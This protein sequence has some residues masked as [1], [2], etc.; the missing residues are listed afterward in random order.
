MNF[1]LTEKFIANL[2]QLIE[3]KKDSHIK[4]ILKDFFPQ[5]IAEIISIIDISE[6]KYLFELLKDKSPE[7]IIEL[8]EDL[9]EILLSN[10]TTKK[11]AKN[12]IE[13][14]E[15]DDAA[16]VIQEMSDPMQKE[17]LS[18]DLLFISLNK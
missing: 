9:R 2:K 15:T 5:D 4:S 6:A 14:L 17:V 12:L 11:I 10:L 18:Q 8:E 16:D 1:K 3:K 7:I 13:N